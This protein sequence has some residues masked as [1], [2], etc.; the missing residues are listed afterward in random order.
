MK[1]GRPLW[2]VAG[3]S[4]FLL[5]AAGLVTWQV[6]DD[7][8]YVAPH[9]DGAAP[10]A[11][12]GLASGALRALE[13][14]VEAGDAE[15]ARALAPP[16][17]GAPRRLLAGLVVNARTAG[18]TDFS[19]RYVT[20]LGAV[21]AD[22]SWTASVDVT[23]A[24]RGFDEAPSRSEVQFRFVEDGGVAR[25]AGIGGGDRRTPVWMSGRLEVRRT[26][27][28]L[29][30]VAG[31]AGEAA[32]YERL[33][34]SAV[35][36][37]RDVLPDW[38]PQ[39]VVEVPG[40]VAALHAALASDQGT[41]D[42]IAATTVAADGSTAPDAPVHVFVNPQVFGDQKARGA[43]IVMTHEAVHIATDASSSPVPLWLLEG[44]ADYVALR[45]TDLSDTVT[46]G[47]II[48]QVRRDGPPAA[49]P[50]P[51]EFDTSAPH[52]GAAYEAAWLACRLLAER[53]GERALV[54]F[55][56]QVDSGLTLRRALARTYGMTEQ[57]FTREWRDLLTDLAA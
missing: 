40:S 54:R 14:A 42:N 45:D 2:W 22:G 41:L 35:P 43:Q 25:V 15:Q 17:E 57:E 32:R 31:D 7:D 55:Y 37:V 30:L 13:S 52:L 9:P 10:T 47:R 3:L 39:L 33:A 26:A 38:R 6:L 48:R 11:A 56:E 29:V 23:W 27:T 46:A 8:R 18:V 12:P 24:F 5:V 49:L 20:E 4:I 51:A 1:A 44:F 34:R 28:T 16:G 36:A 21:E 53:A 19:L 50:G